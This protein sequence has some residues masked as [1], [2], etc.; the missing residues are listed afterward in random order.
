MRKF[1]ILLF[2]CSS[3][4][5]EPKEIR[6]T[7]KDK[8]SVNKE[9]PEITF[10]K[11]DECSFKIKYNK[12]YNSASE[13]DG[14]VTFSDNKTEFYSYAVDNGLKFGLIFKKKPKSNT[15]TF[16]IEGWEQFD[17]FY[18]PP[19]KNE[20]PDGST[21]EINQF[22]TIS[23]RPVNINGSYA[24]YHKTKKDHVIG[25]TNYMTGKVGHIYRPRFI[26]ATGKTTWGKLNIKNGIYTVTIP[27]QFLDTATYP[28]KANDEF[29]TEGTGGSNTTLGAT[30]YYNKASSNPTAGNLTSVHLYS[31][32]Y[33]GSPTFNPALYS[34]DAG[35]PGTRLAYMDSGGTAITSS[36]G[37]FETALSYNGLTATQYWLCH[38]TVSGVY[39]IA[40][41]SGSGNEFRYKDAVTSYPATADDDAGAA[42]IVSI[43][44][45]YTPATARRVFTVN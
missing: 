38:L 32:L 36:T 14:K 37:W 34:D 1:L 4:F 27:Q 45:T 22:G 15:F 18:Q 39:Y 23:N 40:Y 26:D 41:D 35:T 25:Q 12:T 5:S 19:L 3:A 33:S 7:G 31:L 44:A 42:I 6:F 29:G 20:N 2:L 28:V 17:F 8:V 16:E 30:C 43:Y 9:K 10:S 24:I 11:W 13:K 21:W